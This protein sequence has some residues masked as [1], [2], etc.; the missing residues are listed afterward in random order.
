MEDKDDLMCEH[1]PPDVIA[2]VN[3]EKRNMKKGK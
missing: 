3:L 1:P 2:A